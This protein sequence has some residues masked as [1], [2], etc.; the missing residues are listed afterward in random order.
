MASISN[1]QFKEYWQAYTHLCNQ[2]PQSRPRTFSSHQQIFLYLFAVNSCPHPW[3]QATTNV[4]F[5]IIYCLC[6]FYN[7]IKSDSYSCFIL[8]SVTF[9]RIY[10]CCMWQWFVWFSCWVL[11]KGFLFC[12]A[13]FVTTSEHGLWIQAVW[14]E[15]WLLHLPAVLLWA[16]LSSLCLRSLIC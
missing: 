3:P 2:T 16:S 4:I 15:I 7:F 12:F 10:P 9:F 14:L 11:E 8:L 1:T 6:L 5:V 13:V